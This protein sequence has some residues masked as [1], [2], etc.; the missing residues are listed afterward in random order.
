MNEWIK[1]W[2]NKRINEWI[3]KLKQRINACTA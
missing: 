3:N 2:M 1:E